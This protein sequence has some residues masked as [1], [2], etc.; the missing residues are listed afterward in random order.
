MTVIFANKH[1]A[2][3]VHPR[4][5]ESLLLKGR[6]GE[7]L[8]LRP[9]VVP[10]PFVQLR[11]KQQLMQSPAPSFQSEKLN[12]QSPGTLRTPTREGGKRNVPQ[13]S[14]SRAVMI[15]IIM[16]IEMMNQSTLRAKATVRNSAHLL[17]LEG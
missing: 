14:Q 6:K 11:T 1:Q 9:S 2:V 12:L 5:P 13:L 7:P 15:A 17:F 10:Q 3:R 8:I 16:M 4:P